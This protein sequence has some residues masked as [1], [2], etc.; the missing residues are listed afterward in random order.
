MEVTALARLYTYAPLYLPEAVDS[1]C[2]LTREFTANT[3]PFWT[4]IKMYVG[5][6]AITSNQ[7]HCARDAKEASY[8]N[9][10]LRTCSAHLSK[11]NLTHDVHHQ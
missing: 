2:A 9:K 8:A 1:E 11:V 10:Q 5:G 3:C 6:N 7:K 4:N